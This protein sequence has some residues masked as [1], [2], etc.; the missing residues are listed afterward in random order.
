MA[1]T[2]TWT[3]ARETDVLSFHVKLPNRCNQSTNYT[4]RYDGC[5]NGCREEYG[6]EIFRTTQR[7]TFFQIL[8]NKSS[9]EVK[10]SQKSMWI[11]IK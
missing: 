4:T 3:W 8:W 1:P 11:E 10:S 5:H 2:Y 7:L 9:G 6:K